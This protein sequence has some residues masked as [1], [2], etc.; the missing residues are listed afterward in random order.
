M[1]EFKKQRMDAQT[2]YAIDVRHC[3]RDSACLRAAY[4]KYQ[5]RIMEIRDGEDREKNEHEKRRLDI[6][7]G[8][9]PSPGVTLQGSL[10]WIPN[11]VNEAARQLPDCERRLRQAAELSDELKKPFED[12]WIRQS[13]GG[14]R[15]VGEFFAMKGVGSAV[16]GLLK[17]ATARIASTAIGRAI[18][19]R[20][21][22]VARKAEP[23]G[24]PG[25]SPKGGSAEPGAPSGSPSNPLRGGALVA[26][27]GNLAGE[28]GG[29][30][31]RQARH[32]RRPGRPGRNGD[33]L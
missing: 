4:E 3:R 6:A 27:A 31:K 23:A 22:A 19:D 1:N 7:R 11:M 10:Q 29:P 32:P 17:A 16:G 33:S 2:E 21:P 26:E 20:F 14:L 15:E 13:D 9:P 24:S 25:T 8:R 30:G 18:L 28:D 12:R 5:Q